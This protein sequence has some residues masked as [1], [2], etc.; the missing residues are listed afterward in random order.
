MFNSISWQE[1]LTAALWA[2]LG[3]Y[4]IVVVVF[5]PKDILAKVRRSGIGSAS[6]DAEKISSSNLMGNIRPD[7]QPVK[8]TVK[9]D[10]VQVSVAPSKDDYDAEQLENLASNKVLTDL[11]NEIR[12]VARVAAED[13]SCDGL[14]MIKELL[15]NYAAVPAHERQTINGFI[16]KEFR[17]Q[18]SVELN[19][20]QLSAA[21]PVEE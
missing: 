9:S 1:F 12:L 5:Y 14:S 17:A 19:V 20:A 3:Y 2:H 6:S 8:C 21:W 15:S 13:Q 7:P 4:L 11:L 10:D 16:V 18:C